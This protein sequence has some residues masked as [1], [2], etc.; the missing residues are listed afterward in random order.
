M[1]VLGKGS[2]TPPSA[3]L[4]I[5][6]FKR[7]VDAIGKKHES[8]GKSKFVKKIEEI[9]TVALATSRSYKTTLNLS[10]RGMI[11]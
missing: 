5:A 7:L 10:E 2:G 1:A 4:E 8:T 9:P 3:P 11:G 6:A